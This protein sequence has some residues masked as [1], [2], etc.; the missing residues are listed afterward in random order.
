MKGKDFVRR[1]NASRASVKNVK[2]NR[3]LRLCHAEMPLALSLNRVREV[4]VP[5]Y[6]MRN[7]SYKRGSVL[8]A[9]AL[10]SAMALQVT[11][12]F[13]REDGP[14]PEVAKSLTLV[15]AIPA[16]HVLP[17]PEPASSW[18][19]DAT[20]PASMLLVGTLLIGIG[21]VIRRSV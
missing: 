17:I 5:M 18:Q 12:L 21:S 8:L 2:K 7:Q 11:V 20:Q 16:S 3:V 1:G 6:P 15:A 4:L 9:V 13:S 19:E 14:P 10:F